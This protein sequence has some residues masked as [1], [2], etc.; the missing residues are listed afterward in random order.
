MYVIKSDRWFV[1]NN[2]PKRVMWTEGIESA[3][4]FES[5][6]EATCFVDH[7]T[8]AEAK[9]M[10]I[11]DMA[12]DP[13]WLENQGFLYVMN[14]ACWEGKLISELTLDYIQGLSYANVPPVLC[15]VFGYWH[16]IK[17]NEWNTSQEQA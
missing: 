7:V 13:R 11:V 1:V 15:A 2:D 16:K 17:M 9:E 10:T 14:N 12:E 6:D 3:F 5:F 4:R 8:P